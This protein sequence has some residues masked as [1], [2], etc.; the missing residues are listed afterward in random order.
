LVTPTQ[1]LLRL[2]PLLLLHNQ[3]LVQL[4]NH[5]IVHLRVHLLRRNFLRL[6]HVLL[7]SWVVFRLTS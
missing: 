4:R 7:T 1:R 3:Q 5:L 2:L 6:L